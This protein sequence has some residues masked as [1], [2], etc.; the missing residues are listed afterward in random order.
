MV[1]M[2]NKLSLAL[3]KRSFAAAT[4]LR[5]MS[6]MSRA[7]NEELDL[8]MLVVLTFWTQLF[9]APSCINEAT[10]T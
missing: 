10:S 1:W 9:Y 3:A 6:V 8:Y 5:P 4:A 7:L 2:P